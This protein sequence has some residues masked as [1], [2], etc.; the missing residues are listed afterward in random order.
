MSDNNETNID[1]QVNEIAA[2]LDAGNR[3]QARL[4]SDNLWRQGGQLSPDSQQFY[5]ECLLDMGEVEQAR[6]LLEPIKRDI[7]TYIN[8]YWPILL[9]FGFLSCN[10]SSVVELGEYPA[11]YTKMQPVFDW[12]KDKQQNYGLNHFEYIL[13]LAMEATRGKLCAFDILVLEGN[14]I[15]CVFYSTD[16]NTVNQKIAATML[17]RINEYFANTQ[18]ALPQD[19]LVVIENIADRDL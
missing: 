12:L 8:E 6:L 11:I 17:G 14:I 4:L 3:T 1:N 9:K 10:L 13:R 15:E 2:A 18:I 16:D 5:I 19:W 7:N